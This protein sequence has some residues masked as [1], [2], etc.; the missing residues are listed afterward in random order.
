MKIAIC[1]DDRLATARLRG[2]VQKWIREQTIPIEL[3]ISNGSEPFLHAMEQTDFD[4]ALLDI[5]LDDAMTGIDLARIIRKRDSFMTIVFVTNHEQY[6][7]QGIRVNASDY[8]SKPVDEGECRNALDMALDAY[9]KRTKDVFCCRNLTNTVSVPKIDILYCQSRG[10]Y[11]ELHKANTSFAFR[12]T[13]KELLERLPWPQFVQCSKN[14]IVNV[15][16]M[17]CIYNDRV[18]MSNGDTVL[19][20]RRRAKDVN[21]A[22]IAKHMNTQEPGT[23]Y[24]LDV[25]A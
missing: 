8:L 5:R 25:D 13:V 24:T 15:Y 2:F 6:A 1:D 23:I 7:I 9:R 19:V 18:I 20:S 3:H 16:H 4:L 12:M 11:I 21:E 17:E 22:Y 14:T 10:H